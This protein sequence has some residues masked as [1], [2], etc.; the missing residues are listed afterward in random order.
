MRNLAIFLES[1]N[2]HLPDP[3]VLRV[4]YAFLCRES[5]VRRGSWLP[6]FKIDQHDE[7]K[8]HVDC[9]S[10]ILFTTDY[11]HTSHNCVNFSFTSL[12]Y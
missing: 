9:S 11:G 12:V 2:R 10:V 4:Y 3:P 5:N 6:V 7:S 8:Q 1:T